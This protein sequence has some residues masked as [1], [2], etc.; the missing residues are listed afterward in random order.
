[1]TNMRSQSC[2]N[3][4]P[5]DQTTGSRSIY[6]DFGALS[7]YLKTGYLRVVADLCW[8]AIDIDPLADH[9]QVD[10][11]MSLTRAILS[12][13]TALW[14]AILQAPFCGLCLQDLIILTNGSPSK[15]IQPDCLLEMLYRW[16]QDKLVQQLTANGLRIL[17]VALF[18]VAMW[19]QATDR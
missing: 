8:E 14:L 3:T 17:T 6:C 16:Q 13:M 7:C 19:Q 5:R 9:V 4:M 1:M 18:C 2:C 10:D 15:Q 11:L 12:P